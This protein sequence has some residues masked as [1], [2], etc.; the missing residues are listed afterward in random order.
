LVHVL[1]VIHA[2][3]LAVFT[4]LSAVAAVTLPDL[5]ENLEPG[6]RIQ[7]LDLGSKFLDEQFDPFGDSHGVATDAST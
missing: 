4:I 6:I 3:T 5:V 2:V 1:F 7:I